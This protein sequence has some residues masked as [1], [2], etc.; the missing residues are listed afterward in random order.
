MHRTVPFGLVLLLLFTLAPLNHAVLED[1][2]V[3]QR[4][5]GHDPGVSDVP[6]WRIGDRWIYSGTFDPT[7]LVTD[8]G[9]DA[10]VGEIQGDTTSEVTGISM[11]NVDNMSVLAYTLRTSANFDKSGSPWKVTAAMSTFNSHKRSTSASV[12]LHPYAVNLTCTSDSFPAAFPSLSRSSVTSPSRP[13]I[14]R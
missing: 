12:T 5:P 4:N 11:Q 3:I 13:P 1:E 8:T 9:V 7:I 14:L 10:T 2:P 6:V